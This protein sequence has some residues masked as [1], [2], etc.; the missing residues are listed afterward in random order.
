[1]SDPINDSIMEHNP[2]A[3]G[4]VTPEEEA[5]CLEER[6]V[7]GRG[8]PPRRFRCYLR[9]QS[10]WSDASSRYITSSFEC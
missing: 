4:G 5:R 7:P 3:V 1:V 10:A 9:F 2:R 6:N 8:A